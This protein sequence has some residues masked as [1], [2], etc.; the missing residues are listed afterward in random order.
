MYLINPSFLELAK[1]K[2][3]I[4]TN[5]DE[6][7]LQLRDKNSFKLIDIVWNE[8]PQMK[9]LT[10]YEIQEMGYITLEDK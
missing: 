9:S 3:N 6:K 1:S 10:V 7:L 8:Y 2:L 4:K 5:N